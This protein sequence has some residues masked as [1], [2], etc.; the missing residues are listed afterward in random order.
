MDELLR[1]FSQRQLV[2]KEASTPVISE[3]S[4][5]CPE[6]HGA[7]QVQIVCE[8]CP[9]GRALEDCRTCSGR[10]TI[11]RNPGEHLIIPKNEW[12]DVNPGVIFTNPDTAVNENARQTV[13]EMMDMILEALH[14]N[15]QKTD[16]VQSGLAKAID[17]E[18]LYKFISTISNDLF[19]KHITDSVRDIIAYRTVVSEAG[20]LRPAVS[21][22][23]Y[24]IQKPTQF[25]IRTAQD[26]AEEFKTAVEAQMPKVF[27]EKKALDY[28]D[29][30]YNG[31]TVYRKK[32]SFIC[33]SDPLFTFSAADVLSLQ[34]TLP[35]EQI[36][37]H[38][39]ISIWLDEIVQEISADTFVMASYQD[40]EKL[41]KL[42]EAAYEKE[43]PAVKAAPNTEIVDVNK[44]VT[45]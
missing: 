16:T 10:G 6:C 9:G 18:R 38:N 3:L 25:A 14:L 28:A 37:Y 40:I 20:T 44:Q 45:A 21:P 2:D 32:V 35:K 13:K 31:D 26:L 29:K 24:T 5:D 41:V 12:K 42:K 43:Y 8:D 34:A 22:E 1:A 17:Q 11:S 33:Y 19:D 27:L 23:A 30:E 4:V 39:N 7:K 36:V 15:K